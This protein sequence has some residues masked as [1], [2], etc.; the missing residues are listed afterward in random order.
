LTAPAYPNRHMKSRV[1]GT[2]FG[3]VFLKAT[4]EGSDE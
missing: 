3:R 1:F 2:A 4:C